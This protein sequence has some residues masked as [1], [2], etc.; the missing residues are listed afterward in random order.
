M[1]AQ[2]AFAGWPLRKRALLGRWGSQQLLGP[3]QAGGWTG[4]TPDLLLSVAELLR[5]RD[6]HVMACVC[7]AW[8]NVLDSGTSALSFAW[9]VAPE[10]PEVP[11]LPP[12]TFPS[13]LSLWAA[14]LSSADTGERSVAVSS[15]GQRERPVARRGCVQ[16]NG[17]VRGASVLFQHLASVSLRRAVRLQ[18]GALLRL[19]GACGAH[20]QVP[21]EPVHCSKQHFFCTLGETWP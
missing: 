3:G 18:D 9:A 5:D 15:R 17:V 6:V 13:P 1:H 21:N 4:L 8:R 20:L 19:A 16:V 10:A 2:I 14:S 11:H 12:L 7:A